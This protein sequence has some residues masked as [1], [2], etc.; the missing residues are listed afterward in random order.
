MDFK[1]VIMACI[2]ESSLFLKKTSISEKS[3]YFCSVAWWLFL[4]VYTSKIL[5]INGLY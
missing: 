4:F 1:A 5:K 2:A 3:S